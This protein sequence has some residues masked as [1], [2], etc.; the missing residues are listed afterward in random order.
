MLNTMPVTAVV[1]Y[2]DEFLVILF[3]FFSDVWQQTRILKPAQCLD[4]LT[5]RTGALCPSV[6][7]TSLPVSGVTLWPWQLLWRMKI[8]RIMQ[9]KVSVSTT[10]VWTLAPLIWFKPTVFSET[11]FV[12]YII[13]DWK[14]V[15]ACCFL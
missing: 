13:I 7:L 8:L 10:N 2:S 5:R 1:S 3:Y 12:K 6:S 15:N 14:G 9:L 11:H 4:S